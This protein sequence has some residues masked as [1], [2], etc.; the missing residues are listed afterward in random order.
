MIRDATFSDYEVLLPML[1]EL[2]ERGEFAG[3]PYDELMIKRCF[4]TSIAFDHGYARVI[5]K[6]GKVQGCLIGIAAPNAMGINIAQ[7]LFTFSLIGT[8]ILIK[9]FIRWAKRYGCHGVQI[10]D[11]TGNKRYH[12][13]IERMGPKKSGINFLE[14]F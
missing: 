9:D 11:F 4:V 1:I 10:S 3:L 2:H 13:L 14:V 6:N 5:E 7:D 8:H 12:R